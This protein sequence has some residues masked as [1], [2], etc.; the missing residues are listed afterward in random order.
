[1]LQ[2]AVADAEHI[3]DFL[4]GEVF[5]SWL[6]LTLGCRLM[7]SDERSDFSYLFGQFL[8]R[9]TLNSYDFHTLLHLFAAKDSANRAQ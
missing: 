7:L 1:M 3:A 2:C 5:L 6:V 9:R 8:E 4:A